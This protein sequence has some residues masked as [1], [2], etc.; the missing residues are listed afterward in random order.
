MSR[1][2]LDL[3][4][5]PMPPPPVPLDARLLRVGVLCLLTSKAQNQLNSQNR[6]TTAGVV[7][8]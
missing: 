8:A 1:A 3:L 7:H 4:A 6:D 2:W 5:A